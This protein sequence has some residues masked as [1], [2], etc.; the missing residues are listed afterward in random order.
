MFRGFNFEHNLRYPKITKDIMVYAGFRDARLDIPDPP[1]AQSAPDQHDEENMDARPDQEEMG[2]A[3]P[4][5]NSCSC[6]TSKR[7]RASR[8]WPPNCHTCPR[9]HKGLLAPYLWPRLWRLVFFQHWTKIRPTC[10]PRRSCTC[11]NKLRTVTNPG[12]PILFG[13]ILG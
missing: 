4:S 2:Q 9:L 1:P 10:S 13:D 5:T 12:Y 11:T 7:R 3:K 6:W 8:A